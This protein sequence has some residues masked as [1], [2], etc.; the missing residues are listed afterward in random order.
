MRKFFL[1]HC[2]PHLWLILIL[3]FAGFFGCQWTKEILRD[4]AG[5]IAEPA[6]EPAEDIIDAVP[7]LI[8][9]GMKIMITNA[10]AIILGA[11]A[12]HYRHEA[13]KKKTP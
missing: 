8:S 7:Y 6:I 1:R 4:V 9:P 2:N 12:H 13:K 11:I 3:V 10:L 5:G